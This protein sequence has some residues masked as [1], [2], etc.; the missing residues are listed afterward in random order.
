M[1]QARGIPIQ[2]WDLLL[3]EATLAYNSTVNKSMGVSP[4]ECMLGVNPQLPVDQKLGVEPRRQRAEVTVIRTNAEKNREEAQEIYRKRLNDKANTLE[5]S[6]GDKVLM[7]RTFGEYPKISVKWKEDRAGMP[8]TVVAKVGPVNYGIQDSS[9]RQKIYHRNM[10]RLAGERREA[11]FVPDHRAETIATST[12]T[13][14]SVQVPWRVNT[15]MPTL[16]DAVNHQ[17]FT[18]NV[19]R[20]NQ[21]G[22]GPPAPA[23]LPTTRS[24][25]TVKP[26]QRLGI[27]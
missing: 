17:E 23:P 27:D 11:S 24:G 19:F 26:V 20:G 25:R 5:L 2:D 22:S 4:F 6:V 18:E 8:Y 15:S 12:D 13:P 10:L 3:E 7:K 16:A 14:M 9:G 1:C 21:Q